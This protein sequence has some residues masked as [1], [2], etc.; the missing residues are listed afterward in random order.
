MTCFHAVA[1]RL[2]ERK[3]VD[4]KGNTLLISEPCQ[5][6]QTDAMPRAVIGEP[7]LTNTVKVTNVEPSMSKEVLTMYFENA[8]RSNG[9]EIKHLHLE[10]EKKKAFITFKDPSGTFVQ[11]TIMS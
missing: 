8:R 1:A 5:S 2:L 7:P 10:T 11:Y 4:F 6:T 9:G 3:S